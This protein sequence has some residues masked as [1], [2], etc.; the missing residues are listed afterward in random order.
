MQK[1]K[2]IALETVKETF[3]TL[4]KYEEIV[5]NEK[6]FQENIFANVP[7]LRTLMQDFDQ[8]SKQLE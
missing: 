3:D 4:K 7:K 8:N 5:E 1:Q 2:V 6:A